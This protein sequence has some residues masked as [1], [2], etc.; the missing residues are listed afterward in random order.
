MSLD[1]GDYSKEDNAAEFS[2]WVPEVDLEIVMVGR[3]REYDVV[4]T[5]LEMNSNDPTYSQS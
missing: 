4:T 2:L 5:R 3:E 1:C